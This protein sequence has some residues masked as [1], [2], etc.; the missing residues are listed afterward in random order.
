MEYREVLKR[1]RAHGKYREFVNRGKGS[2]RMVA[3]ERE[4]G[5]WLPSYPLPYHGAK[6]EI[7]SGMLRDLRRKF[8][9]PDDFFDD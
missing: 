1:L 3:R 6:T 7:R 4:D 5:R 8:D 9:L 2:H